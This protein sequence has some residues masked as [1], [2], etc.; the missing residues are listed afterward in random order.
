MIGS[1]RRGDQCPIGNYGSLRESLSFVRRQ[2]GVRVRMGEIAIY[3]GANSGSSI[4]T[5]TD[6]QQQRP[7]ARDHL[8]FPDSRLYAGKYGQNTATR[9]CVPA[10]EIA[11]PVRRRAKELVGA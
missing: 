4:W 11:R 2:V 9:S 6:Q 3:Q 10:E 5:I 8:P 1:G 7:S